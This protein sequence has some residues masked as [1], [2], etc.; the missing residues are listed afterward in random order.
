MKRRIVL[1]LSCLFVLFSSGAIVASFYI[2]DTTSRVGRLVKLHQIQDF[3][4]DLVI[5]IQATQSDLYTVRTPL[6]EGLDSIVAHAARL[7]ETARRCT[8]CH[9]AP[10]V[11]KRLEEIQSLT[12]DYQKALS[13]YITASANQ[14][15]IDRLKLD[16]AATG[17][18]L[19]GAIEGMSVE[20]GRKLEAM[21]GAVM[22]KINRARV[23]LYATMA[24]SFISGGIIVV[25]L[26]LSITRPIMALLKGTRAI[27]SGELGYT[28]SHGDKTEF[29]E[30]TDNF[31]SMSAFLKEGYAKLREEIAERE[32]TE[33]ALAKSQKFLSTIFD[34]IHDPFCIIDRD[35]SIVK[36]NGAYADLKGKERDELIR[37]TCFE[38]LENREVICEGCVVEKTF[39]SHDPCSKDKLLAL[40]DGRRMWLEIYTYPV[41]DAEGQASHVVEY[42]RD[43][44]ERKLAEEEIKESKERYEL[45]ARGAN[46]G[47]WDWDLKSNKIFYSHRWKSMLGYSGDDIGDSPEEWLDLV[48]GDDRK[49]LEAKIA[50]HIDGHAPHFESEFRLLHKDG[51]Y[52]WLLSRGLAVRDEA[53]KAYRLVGSQTDITE[54]KVAEEQLLYDAF[55]DALTGLP[56]RALFIDRLEHIIRGIRRRRNYLCS[57]LFLDIDRFKVI[58][59]S[60]GHMIGDQ[61]LVAV[62]QRL[63]R[64]LRPDDTV[65]R[66]GGDEFA[67]LLDDVRDIDE[68]SQI[69]ERIQNGLA[70]PFH[71]GGSE[72]FTT[73]SIGVAM[74]SAEYD[75]PEHML[76]D[77]DIAMYQAKAHGKACYE[78]FDKKMYASITERLQLETD[79]R[80]A[81]EHLQFLI[82]YQPIMNLKT[83]RVIGFEA[84]VRWKHPRRGLIYPLEFIPLAEE[85]GLIFP[86]G[87]WVLRESCRQIKAWQA[88]YPSDPPLKLSVN[89]STKQLS[90]PD[91]AV[92]VGDILSETGLAPTSLAL[93]VTESMIM[94]NPE[95]ATA[96][97]LQLRDLGVHIHID[98][99]G[100]GYSSLSYLHRFPVNALKID[101]SFVARMFVNNENFEIVRTIVTLAQNLDL[102]LIAEGLELSEQLTQLKD[103]KCHYG[104]GFLFSYPLEPNA[105]ES[106]MTSQSPPMGGW[107]QS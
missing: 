31:N 68:V 34:S 106:W 5:S 95:A 84:L 66:F 14:G 94:D 11:A 77:A 42:T 50:S 22:Q 41:L 59:D 58:N 81:V 46:D 45:A 69:V 35:Y 4:T 70:S 25:W 15:L 86:V 97:M 90:Q 28:I 78:V 71:V 75:K 60:L 92:R 10:P 83:D 36:A 72:I 48:H 57:V 76:R 51:T 80:S 33:R 105:I 52:R 91:L 7:E 104:Q 3:R 16:A 13:Y 53:R 62:S 19:L 89:I 21:T 30:L 20:A 24:L 26:T 40:P 17:N 103:L 101:R 54:R 23:I 6:A 85:T 65:A 18:R 63:V 99:F 102:D 64:C 29:G 82:H 93:E 12:K 8:M 32:Q 27:A 37:R 1:S 61:L 9:H 49:Q 74:S 38:T 100:T 67:V 79:L 2:N 44:T 73:A 43:I 39:R 88:R 55:H 96:L 107:Q 56:N 87:Q 47:L 98:D